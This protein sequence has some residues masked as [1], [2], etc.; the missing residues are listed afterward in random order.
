MS[1]LSVLMGASGDAAL[2]GAMGQLFTPLTALSFLSFTVLYMP[3]VAAMAAVRREL[4]STKAALAA[5]GAQTLWAW[6]VTFVL[7]SIVRILI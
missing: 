3:C 6:L 4:H 1:T 2:I 7:Y 5:M